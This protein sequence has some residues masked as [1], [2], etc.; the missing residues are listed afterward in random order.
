MNDVSPEPRPSGTEVADWIRERI[1]RGRFV[2]GQRLVEIDIIRQ[3]GASRSKV[4]EA[5]QRLEGEGLV[6][7]EEFRGASVRA[8][9]LE[10]V[11]Q[12]YRAR[13]ALEGIS[14]ADFVRNAN[15]GHRARLEALQ[16]ELERC[17]TENAPER[18]GRLNTDWHLLLVEGSGNAVIGEVLQRLNVPIHRLLFESFYNADRLATAVADHR[19]IMAAIRANDPEAAEAAMRQ[20]VSDGFRTLSNIDREFHR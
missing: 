9:S 2:P 4:R 13:V 16:D 19:A 17:V 7:I 11:R 15:P 20:H 1:R 6:L 18:F 10:E 8:A 5:L 12:I 14:A 3:T